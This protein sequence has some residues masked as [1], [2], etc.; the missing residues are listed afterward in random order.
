MR[1]NCGEEKLWEKT[2]HEMKILGIFVLGKTGYKIA[3]F[4]ICNTLSQL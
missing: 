2:R 3:H 1:E 4:H